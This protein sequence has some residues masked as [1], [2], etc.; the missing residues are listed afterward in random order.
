[1]QET[2]WEVP[3][4]SPLSTRTVMKQLAP[5]ND[6]VLEQPE[7]FNSSALDTTWILISAT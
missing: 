2:P 3:T 6:A 4:A 1:M 7:Y 5:M